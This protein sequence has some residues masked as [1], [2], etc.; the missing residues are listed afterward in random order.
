MPTAINVSSP[1]SKDEYYPFTNPPAGTLLPVKDFPQ[2]E[3]EPVLFQP[4]KIGNPG[5]E[6]EFRNRIF[7]APCVACSTSAWFRADLK[8]L[9]DSMC[10]YSAA[11]GTGMPGTWHL[12]HL[13]AIAVRGPS[14]I[15]VEATAVLPNGR[16][17]PEDL[18]YDWLLRMSI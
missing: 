6:L 16:I 17:T 5:H 7:V 12:I 15:F 18:G 14:L 9:S 2:N 1:F 11:P 4:I 8:V 13:G 10:Q 3:K